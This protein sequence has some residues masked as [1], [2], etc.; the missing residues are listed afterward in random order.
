M[1]P[2]V[3]GVWHC[4]ISGA[5]LS[6][7]LQSHMHPALLSAA[8]LFPLPGLARLISPAGFLCP[9]DARPGPQAWRCRA[10]TY[11]ARAAESLDIKMQ[12]QQLRVFRD[13]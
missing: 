1:Q 4:I 13:Q 10:P 7:A 12:G 11:G 5:E 2:Q 3:V 8:C 9:W 6:L